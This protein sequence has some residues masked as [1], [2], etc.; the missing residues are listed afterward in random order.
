MDQP[1]NIYYFDNIQIP[2]NI[3]IMIFFFFFFSFVFMKL[4]NFIFQIKIFKKKKFF[5]YKKPYIIS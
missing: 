1:K 2:R 4:F 3:V 5:Y